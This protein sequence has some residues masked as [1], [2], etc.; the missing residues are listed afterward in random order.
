M[1]DRDDLKKELETIS[2]TLRDLG[3][4][5]DDLAVKV[6]RPAPLAPVATKHAA[7]LE[8]VVTLQSATFE[9]MEQVHALNLALIRVE[10]AQHDNKAPAQEDVDATDDSVNNQRDHGPKP[11]PRTDPPFQ[12]LPCTEP[13]FRPPPRDR[14]REEDDYVDSHFHPR[15][16][17]EFPTFDG[18]EDPLP[19]LN[20]CETFFRGQNTPERR[21]VWYAAMHLTGTAQL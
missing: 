17:L 2:T 18:K 8:K 15:V 16:H 13:T 6:D 19:W 14:F 10:S 11:P 12:P 5:F 20:R 21:R 4:K 9:N 1:G 3:A 7:L